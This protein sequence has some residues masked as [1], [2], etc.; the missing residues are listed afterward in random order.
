MRAILLVA[1]LGLA[2]PAA[3]FEKPEPYSPPSLTLCDGMSV[4]AI[5]WGDH[6]CIQVSGE[7][8]PAMGYDSA[9]GLVAGSSGSARLAAVLDNRSGTAFVLG[10]RL[11]PDWFGSTGGFFTKETPSL[12]E[13]FFSTG[14]ALQFRAGLLDAE[15]DSLDQ[16]TEPTW[17]TTLGP[18]L[19]PDSTSIEYDLPIGGYSVQLLARSESGFSV[20]LGAENLDGRPTMTCWPIPCSGGTAAGTVIATARYDGDSLTADFTALA[21]GVLDGN[22]ERWAAK[23]GVD[24]RD[25]IVEILSRGS[26]ENESGWTGLLS[27]SLNFG[28]VTLAG[29]LGA[30]A[31]PWGPFE[32]EIGFSAQVGDTYEGPA[33]GVGA[34]SAVASDGQSVSQ[35][36]LFGSTILFEQLQL[37]LGVGAYAQNSTMFGGE[38]F[39][40]LPSAVWEFSKTSSVA[41]SI[42]THS[43]GGFKAVVKADLRT[44]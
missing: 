14:T 43:S 39:Y 35:A 5:A 13:A 19:D 4:I 25:G 22:I 16:T 6:G 30:S 9:S 24:Y 8:V 3:A 15:F 26:Y 38:D 42:E 41:A 17:L 20:G 28:D 44:Q 12:S 33:I 37:R 36:E 23:G 1:A 2:T 11:T 32:R 40:V 21:G 10:A 29:D 27:A 34:R 18:F 7:F 31:G